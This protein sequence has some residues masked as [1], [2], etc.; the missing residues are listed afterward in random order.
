[1]AVWQAAREGFSREGKTEAGTV[2]WVGR[3]RRGPR[4]RASLHLLWGSREGLRTGD[5]QAVSVVTA[6]AFSAYAQGSIETLPAGRD[7][8]GSLC[9]LYSMHICK[10]SLV[11]CRVANTEFR[12]RPGSQVS[13]VPRYLALLL[14]TKHSAA[15]SSTPKAWLLSVPKEGEH[16]SL[17]CP[18]TFAP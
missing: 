3:C 14:S 15:L 8:Q 2:L 6:S 9:L 11:V 13:L 4:T 12:K 17:D 1:M 7:P 18:M 10:G 16:W 5:A